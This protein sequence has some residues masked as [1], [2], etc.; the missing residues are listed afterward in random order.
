MDTCRVTKGYMTTL[1]VGTSRVA[2]TR[3]I[4]LVAYRLQQH[5]NLF[6]G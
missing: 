2:N 1:G 5:F 3:V 4:A 6:V